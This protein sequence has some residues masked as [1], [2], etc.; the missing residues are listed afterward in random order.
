MND[1]SLDHLNLLESNHPRFSYSVQTSNSY[2]IGSV[3][4][5]PVWVDLGENNIADIASILLAKGL[6]SGIP[7][8][9]KLRMSLNCLYIPLTIFAISVFLAVI[10]LGVLCF[11]TKTRTFKINSSGAGGGGNHVPANANRV[12]IVPLPK[13]PLTAVLKSQKPPATTTNFLVT[14]TET[15][16]SQPAKQNTSK[17]QQ[18]RKKPRKS[19]SSRRGGRPRAMG[20]LIEACNNSDCDFE[21]KVFQVHNPTIVRQQTGVLPVAL[22]GA[23]NQTHQQVIDPISFI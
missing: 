11:Y 1:G 12:P 5:C 23:A 3:F 18:P 6:D 13:N 7:I 10:F 8:E 4:Q 22:C 17:S 16:T 9:I 14:N 15:T 2:E 19:E 21:P 20:E